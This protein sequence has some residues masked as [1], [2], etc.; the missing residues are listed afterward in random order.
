MKPENPFYEA[1]HDKRPPQRILASEGRPA[2]NLIKI[3]SR[4]SR[5]QSEGGGGS[6]RDQVAKKLLE[7]KNSKDERYLIFDDA[8]LK[9]TYSAHIRGDSGGDV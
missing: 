3:N 1:V 8:R 7:M 5:S 6:E 9:E 2:D 4:I